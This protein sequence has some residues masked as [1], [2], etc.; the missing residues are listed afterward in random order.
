[1]YTLLVTVLTAVLSFD[2]EQEPFE[3]NKITREAAIK[4]EEGLGSKPLQINSKV[5][6]PQDF[7]PDVAKYELEQPLVFV[8]EDKSFLYNLEVQ[9]F[10]SST[11]DTIRLKVYS[12]GSRG[13][14]NQESSV[15]GQ[16]A[17]DAFSKKYDELLS[18]LIDKLGSPSE[19]DGKPVER[20][21]G[22][23]EWTERKAKWASE[24]YNSEL[25][26]TCTTTPEAEISKGVKSVPTFRI[27]LKVY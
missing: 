15:S 3:F 7:F 23:V 6:I 20:K 2:S 22:A 14:S 13:F 19:G 21:K 18:T 12:W 8:R 25:T 5:Y 1:M 16:Q 27:R 11:D 4:I 17:V 9:Y 24:K 10:F 26:M